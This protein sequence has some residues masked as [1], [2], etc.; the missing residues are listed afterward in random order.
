VF[1]DF[2]GV[3]ARRAREYSTYSGFPRTACADEAK[4]ANELVACVTCVRA[5]T[6]GDAEHDMPRS[7]WGGDREGAPKLLSRH[8]SDSTPVFQF[9]TMNIW[10]SVGFRPLTLI[11]LARCHQLETELSTDE[12][13]ASH[14]V[15]TAHALGMRVFLPV[16]EQV[17]RTIAPS[18]TM[19]RR[20]WLS[21]KI[22]R[23]TPRKSID[24]NSKGDLNRRN[25]ACYSSLSRARIP[26]TKADLI[27]NCS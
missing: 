18:S 4:V 16:G 27:S 7:S 20:T 25:V 24:W 11:R 6:P 23:F 21:S 14:S 1:D 8:A 13:K 2:E 5:H 10:G 15:T 22:C 17:S 12:N 9:A 26:G 19:G 3:A